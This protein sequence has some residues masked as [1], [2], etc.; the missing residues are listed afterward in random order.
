MDV[1]KMIETLIDEIQKDGKI[2]TEFKNDPAKVIERIIGKD[3]PDD[4]VDKVVD[5]VKAKVNL[6]KAVGAID[7]LDDMLDNVDLG[8][9]DGV[10]D[11]VGDVA[12]KLKNLF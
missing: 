8:K 7:K 5:G 10:M 12:G 4:V 3:L 11:K 9:A 2:G 6:D 1:K